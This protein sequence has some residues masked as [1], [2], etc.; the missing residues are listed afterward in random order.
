MIDEKSVFVSNLS[1]KTSELTLGRAFES[2]G[3]IEQV[4]ILED[5][6]G[7]SRGFGYV[8]FEKKGTIFIKESV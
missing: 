4:K 7:R 5:N 2:C 6:F 3:D 8:E 1:W